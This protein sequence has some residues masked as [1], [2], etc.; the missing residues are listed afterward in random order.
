LTSSGLTAIATYHLGSG[1]DSA[2]EKIIQYL[3]INITFDSP[4]RFRVRITDNSAARWEVP[5]DLSSY[6]IKGSNSLYTASYSINP[7]GL[8][9]TRSSD[10][11][12]L[13]NLDP[14]QFFSY[15]DQDILFTNY[16]GYDV[17]VMGL[18]ERITS[19][20]IPQGTYTLFANGQPSPIDNGQDLKGNM[21]GIHSFHLIVAEDGACFGGFLYNSNAMTA[22]VG[23]NFLSFRLTGGIID[24]WMFLGPH[25]EDVIFQFHS[26]INFPV[27]LPYWSLGWHQSRYGFKNSSEMLQVLNNYNLNKLPLDVL[28]SDIDY[29]SSFEDFTLDPVNFPLVNMTSLVLNLQSSGKHW[30]PIIDAGTAQN[31]SDPYYVKGTQMNVWIQ[32]PYT[33]GA[34]AVG[35]VWPGNATFIDWAHPNASKYWQDC[36]NSFS[37][38]IAFSGIWLDMNEIE[39]FND[40]NVGHSPTIINNLTMPWTPGYDLNTNTLDMASIHYD[41]YPSIPNSN[42]EYNYH[43]LYGYLE[44]KTTSQWFMSKKTRPF[45]ISRSTFAGHGQW[46]SH[47]L[48]DNYSQ[49]NFIE[50]SIVGVFNFGMFGIPMVGADICGFKG[51]S[52]LELCVRWTEL[53]TLYP[54]ARNHNDIYSIDQY[55]W[56]FGQELIDSNFNSIRNRYMLY[57][58]YYTQ[59]TLLSMNGGQFFKPAFWTYPNDLKLLFNATSSFMLGDALIVHPCIWHGVTGSTSFFPDD[60][61]YNLYSGKYLFLDYDNSAYLDMKWPGLVNI[62]VTQGFV[63]PLVDN[64]LTAMSSRDTRSSNLTLLIIQGAADAVGTV[65][66]DDG[67]SYGTLINGEFTQV[68]YN[69][70]SINSTF[71]VLTVQR[72]SS[73]YVRSSGEWPFISTLV[74][75]GCTAAPENVYVYSDGSLKIVPAVVYW[76]APEMI[77]KVWM[78]NYL[79]PD[80]AATVYIDYLI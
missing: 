62:H 44:S 2:D 21:Y 72:I 61:W 26:L 27:H 74:F 9:I 40:G 66:F 22:T 17:N 7:M 43:S 53:G 5:Y 76:N 67:L 36:L 71:D 57:L 63:L 31:L 47:W 28:W 33:S 13:F 10:K 1:F 39:S 29:M 51:N 37:D 58:Y 55:P 69:F 16:F 52:N 14:T 46:A 48:G 42:I 15:D 68:E 18:G 50:Y 6:T 56:S 60:A 32:D 8:S 35:L 45:I 59:M 78:K 70:Y 75:Y 3:L 20:V 41:A 73:G 38:L 54:F 4:Q 23:N 34:P 79:Q 30:V 64:Y 25:P 24:Y 65:V 12:L 77:C 19:F 11:R 49:W 80:Q